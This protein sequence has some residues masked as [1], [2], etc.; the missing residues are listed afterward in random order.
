MTQTRTGFGTILKDA[1]LAE[2]AHLDAV[3]HV[4][5]AKGLR[6]AALRSRI[7]PELEGYPEAHHMVELRV[8]PGEVPRLWI[9][10]ISSVVMAPDGRTYR[11]EQDGDGA[12]RVLFETQNL[13]TMAAEVLRFIAYRVIAREKLAA[14]AAQSGFAPSQEGYGLTAVIYIWL[15]GFTAGAAMLTIL[16]ILLK[17]YVL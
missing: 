10:L 1:R 4:Q 3:L 13:E 9:D 15:T 7:A 12:R 14:T 8:M 6:L 11:L 17:R 5:D 2:A 16:A